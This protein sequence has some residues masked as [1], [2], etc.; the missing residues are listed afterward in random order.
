MASAAGEIADQGLVDVGR[1]E[2]ELL[3][4]LGERQFGDGHLVFDRARRS[5]WP[6]TGGGSRFTL[7]DLGGEQIADDPVRLMLALHRG[8]DDLVVGRPHAAELHLAHGVHHL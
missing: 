6:R 1:L 2:V 5:A 7:A 4:L 8:L 3:Q